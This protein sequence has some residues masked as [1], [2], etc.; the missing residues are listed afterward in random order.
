MVE[1]PTAHLFAEKILAKFQGEIV[2]NLY[3]K[4]KRIYVDPNLIVGRKLQDCNARGKNI[5]LIFNGYAIRLHL[6]LYGTIHLYD[7]NEDL[8]KPFKRVRLLINFNK[9][10][11]V[12]YNAPIVELNTRDN[13]QKRLDETVGPDILDEEINLREI[14]ESIKSLGNST[15]SK[16]LL[17]QKLVSG[18]GNILR[19]EVLYRAKIHPETPIESLYIE[20]IMEILKI[21][22]EFSRK[23]YLQKK[24]GGRLKPLLKVYNKYKGLCRECGSKIIFFIQKDVGRKTFYCPSCQR[25]DYT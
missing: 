21:A 19:N 24:S 11:L 12:V 18:I 3:I 4:S 8:S 7:V 16:A 14:A 17:D 5:I 6:M 2:N 13:I 10:K 22:S 25:I 20:K 23:W 15:I 1:G 9:G